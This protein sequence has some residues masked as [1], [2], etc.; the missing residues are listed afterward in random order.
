MAKKTFPIQTEYSILDIDNSNSEAHWGIVLC[1]Y[2]IEYV[3][4][5][6]ALR[7]SDVMSDYGPHAFVDIVH[8]LDRMGYRLVD[9]PK[10]LYPEVHELDD[11]F[12]CKKCGTRL[13]ER[14]SI[15]HGYCEECKS[16]VM[17]TKAGIFGNVYQFRNRTTSD[18][19]K[20]RIHDWFW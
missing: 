12:R 10:E 18:C 17:N 4:D 15:S 8:K 19:I 2:G 11:L 16:T 20:A 14:D 7:M 6:I 13:L 9:C 3:E 1:K 5:L